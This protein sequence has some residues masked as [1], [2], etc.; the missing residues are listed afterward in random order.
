MLNPGQ[1]FSPEI[2][3]GH[4]H[5]CDQDWQLQCSTLKKKIVW[6]A[7]QI[8]IRIIFMKYCHLQTVSWIYL[9]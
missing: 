2:P 4:H 1:M 8:F 5:D 7:Q 6:A 9:S 3:I